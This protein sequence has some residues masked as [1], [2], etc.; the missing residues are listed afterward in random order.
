MIALLGLLA[1]AGFQNRDKLGGLLGGLNNQGGFGGNGSL[2]N[3]GQSGAN[4]GGLGGMLGGLLGGNA[5]G[6]AGG[7]AGAGA[8]GLGGLLSGG[9]GGL[10]DH[11]DQAGQP[12]KVQGW[13][14]QGPNDPISDHELEKTLGSDTIDTLVKQTGLDRGELLQR[15]SKTLPEAVDKLTPD[16]RIPTEEEVS[17]LSF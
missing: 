17:K 14:N 1:T 11:F 15:L 16:G 10:F 12:N 13:V 9:L 2:G 8:G 5:G 6:L 7:L 3:A 4:Q